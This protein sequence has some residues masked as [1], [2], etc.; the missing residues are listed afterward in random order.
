MSVTASKQGNGTLNVKSKRIDPQLVKLI[1]SS[2]GSLGDKL[3]ELGD[4]VQ[5]SCLF[6]NGAVHFLGQRQLQMIELVKARLQVSLDGLFL[7]NHLLDLLSS[8]RLGRLLD[9]AGHYLGF[10]KD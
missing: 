9:T 10:R 1:F 7:G 4:S 8:V 2:V 3:D 5:L 6:E